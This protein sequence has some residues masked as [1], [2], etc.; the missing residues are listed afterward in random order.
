MTHH[1][2][3]PEWYVKRMMDILASKGG[4][5]T[6]FGVDIMDMTI[7]ELRAAVIDGWYKYDKIIE[8]DEK[9]DL[10]FVKGLKEG[11]HGKNGSTD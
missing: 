4:S 11:L 9:R 3:L 5:M 6:I 2:N 8:C 10:S 1:T 7:E